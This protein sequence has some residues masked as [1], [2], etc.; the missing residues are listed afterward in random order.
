[1]IAEP[2]PEPDSRCKVLLRTPHPDSILRRPGRGLTNEL[3]SKQVTLE[4]LQLRLREYIRSTISNCELTGL[5]LARQAQLAQGHLSN[6]LNFRQGLSLESIDR[7]LAAL[8]IGVLDLV[9]AEEIQQWYGKP[10]PRYRFEIV[11]RISR[12]AAMMPQLPQSKVLAGHCVDNVLLQRLRSNDV[13]SR[14]MWQRFVFIELGGGKISSIAPTARQGAM[15]LVDRHYTSLEPYR[16]SRQ[17]LYLV[18]LTDGL[19]AGR[20]SLLNS[21]LILLPCDQKCEVSMV[22]IKPHE[23][24]FEHIVGRVCQIRAEP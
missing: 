21:H 18:Q 1:M 17:N 14:S 5:A 24:Y 2:E 9:T 20:L 4:T 16:R 19:A 10:S 8:A 11:P 22:E 12:A 15:V 6:F 13:A 7:L 3:G 23:N